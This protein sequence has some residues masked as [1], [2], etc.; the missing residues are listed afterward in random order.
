MKKI[1]IFGFT[2]ELLCFNHALINALDF[3]EKGYEVTLIIE[4]ASA[5]LIP[6]LIGDA[7]PFKNH[8]D[9]CMEKGLVGGVCR[10]CANK[11]GT[12]EAAEA[13][14]FTILGDLFGHPSMA[15]YSEKGYDI[16]TI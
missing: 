14:G 5:G 3:H 9:K 10:A 13:Y 2:G 4:G 16:I 7:N 12:L 15:A 6:K 8:F 1:A 11:L